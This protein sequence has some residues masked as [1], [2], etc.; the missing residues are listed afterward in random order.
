MPQMAPLNWL[1]LLIFF[2]FILIII[3]IIN[4]FISSQFPKDLFL[5]KISL[6]KSW[7]W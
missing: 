7:K 4:Y 1:S 6:S 3:S 2:S 5:S